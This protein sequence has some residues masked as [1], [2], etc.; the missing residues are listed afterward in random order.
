MNTISKKN[1]LPYLL[2]LI[3]FL[4][5][6]IWVFRAPDH[7][8]WSADLYLRN[9]DTSVLSQLFYS[10]STELSSDSCIDGSRDGNIVTFSDLPDLRTLALFRFDP[11]NTQEPY[12]VTHVGFL[13]NGEYFFTM[14][15]ADLEAQA[16]PVNASWQLNGEELEFSPQNTDSSF[17]LPADSVR[18]A[19]E[20][21]A[22]RL[23][24]LYVRQRFFAALSAALLL[25]VLLFFRKGIV[26]YL[27]TLFLPDS[28]GHFD[29]FSLIC[30]AVI[31]GALLVVCIIGLFSA[32]G[33]HPDEWDV[34]ACLD[35]GMTHFLPPDMRD[36]AVAQTYS[37]Y[38]YTK[39][40]NY[41]WYFYLAG[42]VALLFKTLFCSLAYYRVPN[43]LL[44]AALAFYFVRHI[45]RKNWLMV[46][47]GICVQSWY[48]FSYTTADALDFTIA[49]VIVCLLSN[50]ESL[51]YRT[52]E[53][54]K[55]C[56]KDLSTF[57]VLGLLFGNIAL[58]K[59]C[60]LAILALSFFVLLLRLIWQKDQAQKNVLWRNYL[61]IV[62]IFLAVFAFRAGFDVA[63]Y[64]TEKSQ[65]KEAVAI[66]YADYDKNPSTPTEELNPS[67]HMYSRGYSLADVFAENPDWFAMSYKSFC[68]LLQDHD[69]GAWY[70]WC[71]GLLYLA[72]FAGIG[73]ATFRQT[74]NLQGRI[75][76][77]ICTLLMIGEL[78]ASIVNSW[79][80]ESM[81]Q[82]RYLLP[83][84]L[85]AGYL[86]STVPELFRK[87]IYRAL[88]CVAGILSVGYFGLVGIPL[89]F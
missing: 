10:E 31:A 56:K 81:A 69:T 65:V 40:E 82:G 61:I 72:L 42:K 66:Q 25:C 77:L 71:M 45:R 2:I 37:G 9:E 13:L 54:K 89:F 70:Y 11:T 48:I 16:S 68:G 78:A 32:L 67:W 64:G 24:V 7:F 87:K 62:G 15:A 55:L 43:L 14:E 26:S 83:C 60:Y 12:R 41:T 29:W 85:I 8:S 51:L 33:L 53:K 6:L 63:H 52:V 84:I 80:I 3:L 39:L 34:K 27:K 30:T 76:F 38:G 5:S 86:A 4:V 57:L 23:H 50:P 36:P 20:A 58:G 88:L 47:F 59:Q 18:Q 17:L 49:F 19:A 35:Y 75:R 46:A 74:D 44:F 28:S 79:L 73:I 21:T 1:L 22:A